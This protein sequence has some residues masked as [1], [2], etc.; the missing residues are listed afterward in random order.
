MA[1]IPR[2][3]YS[4]WLQGLAQVPAVVQLCFTRWA[5]LNPEYRLQMLDATH[6]AA[7][8]V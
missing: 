4:A 1:P 6:A 3:I 7:L 8:L 2:V 5:R